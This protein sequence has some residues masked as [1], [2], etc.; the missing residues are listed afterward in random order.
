MTRHLASAFALLL[1]LITCTLRPAHA[2]RVYKCT[3]GA[4]HVA[5]Q[6]IPCGVGL[7]ETLIEIE[8]P[9]PLPATPRHSVPRASRPAS[10][11]AARAAPRAA[12]VLSYECR[13]RGG[14]L[15]YRH[16]RCPSS[17]DR[18]GQIGGRHGGSRDQVSARRIPRLDAC[19]GMRSAGRDGREFDDVPSTYE[20]NLGR[21]PCRKY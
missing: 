13:T 11:H 3:D 9:P 8:A 12:P 20:R 10:T 15:F 1:I 6:A 19:R 7:R 14:A 2:Q 4:N 18:S 16:D 17:I 5:Y 21:D